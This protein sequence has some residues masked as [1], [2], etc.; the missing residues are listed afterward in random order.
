MVEELVTT[1]S[2]EDAVGVL[3]AGLK[4]P[5]VPDGRP[6]TLQLTVPL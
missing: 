5:V 2:V 1:V 6:L 4:V 3:D